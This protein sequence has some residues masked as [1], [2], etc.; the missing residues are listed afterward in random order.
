MGV[1][2]VAVV[3]AYELEE[4]EKAITNALAYE[5]PSV[6]ILKGECMLQLLRRTKKG[7]TQTWVDEETCTGCKKCVQLGCPAVTYSTEKKKAGIDGINCTDC[8]LCEQVCPYDAIKIGG[9]GK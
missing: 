9:K 6:V 3:N 8:G 5:G 4:A 2:S 1:R 7:E